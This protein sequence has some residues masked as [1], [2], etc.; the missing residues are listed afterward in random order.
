[1]ATPLRM[2]K[3]LAAAASAMWPSSLMAI[4]SSNPA[5]LASVTIMAE[6]TYAPAILPRAGMALSSIRR[7][8]RRW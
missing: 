5:S 7:H 4:A 1:M 8:E 6:L 2:M 3:K